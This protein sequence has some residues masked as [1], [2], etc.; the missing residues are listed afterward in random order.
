M[1]RLTVLSLVLAG[2]LFACHH[3]TAV[4][5][6]QGQLPKNCGLITQ[7]EAETVFGGHLNPARDLGVGCTYSA[8]EHYEKGVLVS[9]VPPMGV[10]SGE[11]YYDAV[12]KSD[13]TAT[14]VPVGGLGDKAHFITS[15][16]GSTVTLQVLYHNSVAVISATTSKNPNLKAALTQAIRQMM[17]KF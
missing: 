11:T 14:A 13:P 7:Q 2:S 4:A 1:K 10:A 5:A 8:D 15:K 3:P 9:L 16:D 6:A 17:Q 12:L